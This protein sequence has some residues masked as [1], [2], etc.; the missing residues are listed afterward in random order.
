MNASEFYDFFVQAIIIFSIYSCF[1]LAFFSFTLS[2]RIFFFIFYLLH[3]YVSP[4]II[5]LA[6]GMNFYEF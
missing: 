3:V 1:Y 6:F 2:V 4:V 5:P